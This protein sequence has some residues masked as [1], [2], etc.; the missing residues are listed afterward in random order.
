MTFE[1]YGYVVITSY[2]KPDTGADVTA[3]IQRAIDEN[4]NKTIYFPDGEYI[5]SEPITTPAHPKKSVSLKLSNYAKIKAAPTWSS[6]E[7]MIRLGATDFANDIDTAGSNYYLEGGIIDGADIAKGVSIDG[8]R[9]TSVRNLSMKRVFVGLHIKHGAN[10]ASSDCD[11]DTVNIVGNGKTG[12]VGVLIE[13]CDNTLTNMRIAS[14]QYGMKCFR[15]GNFFRNVHP[16]FIYEPELKA[17]YSESYGFWDISNGNW[18]DMCYSDQFATG[19]YA[20]PTS[21]HVYDICRAFWYSPDG[22]KQV[23]F[24]FDGKMNSI[25][26]SCAVNLVYKEIE[27]RYMTVKE[28]G[29]SGVVENPVV[30]PNYNLDDSY[31]RYSKTKPIWRA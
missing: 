31:K 2:A 17:C 18:Y 27:S 1:D 30:D 11:I 8:G 15:A 28:E 3:D 22:K 21:I 25:M 20:G 5:I 9:E 29:G 7:A 26:N 13:A 19:F 10:N 6:S 4:P 16:L 12:S 23:G 24:E 14:V